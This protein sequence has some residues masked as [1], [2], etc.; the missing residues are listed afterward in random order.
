MSGVEGYEPDH[1]V[2]AVRDVARTCRFYEPALGIEPEEDRPGTWTLYVGTHKPRVPAR[3]FRQR[4][5]T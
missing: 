4:Q 1:I 3:Q 5:R 2:F